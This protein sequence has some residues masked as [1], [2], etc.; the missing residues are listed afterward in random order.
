MDKLN[1][2]VYEVSD[3]VEKLISEGAVLSLC[4][5]G[6]SMNPFLISRRDIVYIKSVSNA[7]FKKFKVLLFRRSDGSLVLHRVVKV[8]P[9][10]RLIMNGD[11]QNWTEIIDVSQVLAVVDEIERKGKRRKADSLYWKTV[12][13][14]WHIMMPVRSF[15]MRVWFKIRRM[16]NKN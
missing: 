16:K 13:W 14:I 1:C 10:G 8:L 12:N 5:S 11:A 9:D 4:V 7:D 6:S 2:S 3:S 15:I